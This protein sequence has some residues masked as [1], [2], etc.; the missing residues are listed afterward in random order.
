[1]QSHQAKL[2]LLDAKLSEL[3][4]HLLAAPDEEPAE[5]LAA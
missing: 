1:L 4:D 5:A 3:T 2:N